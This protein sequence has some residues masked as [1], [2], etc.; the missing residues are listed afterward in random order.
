MDSMKNAVRQAPVSKRVPSDSKHKSSL[1]HTVVARIV[2][3][4]EERRNQLIEIAR[5]RG[6]VTVEDLLE[7]TTPGEID[8]DEIR[9][10]L[11]EAGIELLE[12]DD[13]EEDTPPRTSLG[14]TEGSDLTA[15]SVDA[16]AETEERVLIRAPFLEAEELVPETPAAIYLRDISRVPLLTAEEEVMLA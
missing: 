7:I 13:E 10:M 16:A 15:E 6:Y 12:S 11:E 14:W 5:T 2:T 4:R 8:L 9:E 3:E 1:T